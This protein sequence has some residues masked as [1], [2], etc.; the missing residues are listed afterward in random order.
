MKLQD[1][2]QQNLVRPIDSLGSDPELCRQIQTRLK[3]LG[4]L[5]PTSVDGVYGTQTHQAFIQFKEFTHQANPHELGPGSAKVLI[6]LKELPNGAELISKV[7]AEYIYGCSIHF[8]QL[9]DLNACLKQFRINTPVRMRHFLS[10]TAHE[11]GGLQFLKEIDNGWKY[12][13]RT[14]LGNTQPGDGP[15]YKGAG[16]IQLTGRENYQKFSDFIG[17]PKVMDGVDYVSVTYP[18]TSAGFWWHN[19]G[20][21]ALCDRGASVEE[22]TEQVNG[23][24]NGLGDRKYYYQKACEVIPD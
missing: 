7:Q 12:E 6:E 2:I 1:I 19:N 18:F 8:Q 9:Q 10:Q 5:S 23:G 24:F 3:D 14:G 16:V 13:G 20:M 17:D 21:N 4:L 11:S 22:I 15:K